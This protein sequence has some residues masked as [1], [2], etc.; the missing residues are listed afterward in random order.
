[1]QHIALLLWTLSLVVVLPARGQVGN[2]SSW[3]ALG[4]LAASSKLSTAR[5]FHGFERSLLRDAKRR[6]FAVFDA[7]WREKGRELAWTE[8]S[9]DGDGLVDLAAEFGGG[10][11]LVF[12]HSQMQRARAR[13]EL[14]T[15]EC[16]DAVRIW[17][18]GKE[19]AA[20]FEDAGEDDEPRLLVE[21]PLRAGRNDLVLK[22]QSDGGPWGITWKPNPRIPQRQI[23]EAIDRGV[24]CLGRMQYVD[25]SWG[26]RRNHNDEPGHV[27]LTLYT[28]LRCGAS[29]DDPVVRRAK[30]F[31]DHD[32]SDCNYS[33]A[34]MVLALCACKPVDTKRVGTL[35]ARIRDLI[36]P[37]G[38]SKYSRAGKNSHMLPDLSN[39][40]FAALAF[41]DAARAGV[42]VPR[43]VWIELARGALAAFEGSGKQRG[44]AVT[45]DARPA[46]FGYTPATKVYGSMTVSGLGILAMAK[47]ALGKRMPRALRRDCALAHAAGHAWLREHM[48]FDEN[49]ERDDPSAFHYF[50]LWGLERL[51]SLE[52]RALL[53]GKDWYQEGAR[54][55]LEEQASSGS[56]APTPGVETQLALLFLKRAT[57]NAPVTGDEAAMA[58]ASLATQEK[59]ADVFLRGSARENVTLWIDRF[60]EALDERLAS[61]ARITRAEWSAS[62]PGQDAT[63]PY[64]VRKF[65]LADS[66]GAKQRA[67]LDP[68]SI[69]TRF[70]PG[71][72]GTWK[73]RVTLR[74]EDAASAGK[75]DSYQSPLLTVTVT[76]FFDPSDLR[77]ASDHERDLLRGMSG[78]ASRSSTSLREDRSSA[79]T[80]DG[81]PFTSWL[82]DASDAAPWIELQ[83]PKRQRVAR[84]VLTPN[85]PRLGTSDVARP[86]RGVVEIDGAELPF[87]IDPDP[88]RKT[89]L[90]LAKPTKLRRLRIRIVE[91]RDGELGDASVGF[92][93]IE[94]QG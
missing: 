72:N 52:A 94:L 76:D 42:K 86:R 71:G 64:D 17:L 38:L 40:I 45:G 48:V 91:A 65:A 78:L 62:G 55:L 2:A 14:W 43:D 16:D 6:R 66:G 49:P 37:N 61:G 67:R 8:L 25:G 3:R 73:L 26:Y 79:Q 68:R 46:G 7:K 93:M 1:M 50:W 80:I 24:A 31:L 59:D 56:W 9:A 44:R 89:T 90:R 57:E 30:A 87:T 69:T 36:A 39:S 63:R 10:P 18:N 41:R 82:C 13:A 60:G 70:T 92:S 75:P 84:I 15:L 21:L 58:G 11:K 88:R 51:G 83:W 32:D 4:P 27:A 53:G 47:D 23:H 5:S 74:V 28:L 22:V 20:R 85:E 54:L 19:V 77:F 12:L 34:T 29:M 81:L 35:V 33:L